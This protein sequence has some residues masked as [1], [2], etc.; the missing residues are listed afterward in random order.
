MGYQ[1]Q[2]GKRDPRT[3]LNRLEHVE[4][5]NHALQVALAVLQDQVAEL[6][7]RVTVAERTYPA[8]PPEDERSQIAQQHLNDLIHAGHTVPDIA[9]QAGVASETIRR[10]LLSE[11]PR[12]KVRTYR[13]IMSIPAP[14]PTRDAREDQGGDAA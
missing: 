14:S 2:S 5:A 4:K 3:P 1:Y 9:E 7:K 6:E 11:N 12:I 8:P 13:N 10:V